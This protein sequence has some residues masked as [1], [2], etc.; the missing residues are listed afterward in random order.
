MLVAQPGAH[1]TNI[2]TAAAKNNL[3]Q[4]TIPDYDAMREATIAKYGGQHGKQPGDPVKA[5][6]A[7][8][9]VV[10]GEGLA[11]G[12]KMPLWLLL[13]VDAEQNLRDRMAERTKNMEEWVE[14]TRSVKIDDGNIVLV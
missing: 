7:I 9:D 4:E 13:G 2:V 11:A 10:R 3:W 5:M 8:V 14:V 1:R 12:K 6:N